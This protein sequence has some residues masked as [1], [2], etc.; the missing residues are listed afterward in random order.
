[1]SPRTES[2]I[3]FAVNKIEWGVGVEVEGVVAEV[4]KGPPAMRNGEARSVID[5]DPPPAHQNPDLVPGPVQDLGLQIGE[6]GI[7]EDEGIGAARVLP[8]TGK[9]SISVRA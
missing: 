5:V 7:E 6:V 1:M 4:G 3:K 8:V 2:Y 9:V